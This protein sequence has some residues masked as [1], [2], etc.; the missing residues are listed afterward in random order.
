MWLRESVCLC[1]CLFF[2]QAGGDQTAEKKRGSVET[3]K[4]N[5][6]R[7]FVFLSARSRRPPCASSPPPPHVVARLARAASGE[8]RE[9]EGWV[10]GRAK[11]RGARSPVSIPP[12]LVQPGAV[13]DPT[14]ITG[15]HTDADLLAALRSTSSSSSSSPPPPVFVLFGSEW[16]AHC[17]AAL[18]SLRSARAALPSSSP[19]RF[20][21][22]LV[23]RM[24]PAA[25]AVKYTP[26][27]VV[28]RR[29]KRVDC[30]VGADD[31]KI[32]DRVWLH[33]D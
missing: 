33:C 6:R 19:A 3:A 27:L 12:S 1:V 9:R 18:A 7:R 17:H 2:V 15:A 25:D 8:T 5:T 11:R 21:A 29:G 10:G 24:G 28:Y 31:Q 4:K 23:D 30:V 13:S 22:A 32:R 26:S 14:A 20:V 16:C